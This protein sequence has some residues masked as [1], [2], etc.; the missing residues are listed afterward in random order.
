MST[1]SPHEVTRLLI[2]LT[3]GNRTVLNELLPLVYSELRSLA[4]N[5]LRRSV[6]I[7]SNRRWLSTRVV[8]SA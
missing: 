8:N 3:D 7:A 4:A 5:Y 2:Q 6:L 1:S